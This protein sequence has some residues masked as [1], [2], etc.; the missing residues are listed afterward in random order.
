MARTWYYVTE[1][2][3]GVSLIC[4]HN[5]SGQMVSIRAEGEQ[6]DC[7]CFTKIRGFKDYDE[8]CE[9]CEEHINSEEE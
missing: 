2:L 4:S 6:G 9:Y 7:D 8:F 1:T 5:P 3:A